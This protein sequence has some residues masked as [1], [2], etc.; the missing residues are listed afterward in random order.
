MSVTVLTRA[1]GAVIGSTPPAL[2]I[3]SDTPP[4]PDYAA[5]GHGLHARRVTS[6]FGTRRASLTEILPDL[7]RYTGRPI[8]PQAA[9]VANRLHLTTQVPMREILWTSGPSLTLYEGSVEIRTVPAWQVALAGEPAGDA[10]RCLIWAGPER[11]EAVLHTVLE[12]LPGGILER[13]RHPDLERPEWLVQ[14]IA[15]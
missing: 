11:A 1:P 10:L 14:M 9:E 5:I 15:R 13:L 6:R 3:A 12:R 7:I 4:G 8:M 2:L